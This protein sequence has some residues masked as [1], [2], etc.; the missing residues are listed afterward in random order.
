MSVYI[1]TG[2][3]GEGKGIMA[4]MQIQEALW[5]KKRVV[6]NINL[7]LENFSLKKEAKN[8]LRCSDFPPASEL[9]ALG[10]GYP[11]Y[12]EKKFGLIVLDEMGIY[13]NS[14]NFKAEG[15]ED[16]IKWLRHVRKLHW[17]LMILV[18]S[19]ES[20]DKQ[21]RN[22]LAHFQV[23]CKALDK[24]TVPFVSPISK[25]FFNRKLTLP[26]FHFGLVKRGFGPSAV[27]VD[28]WST[29]GTEFYK[30]YDTGQ[31]YDGQ[32]EGMA[33]VLDTSRVDYLK[34]PS[35]PR[36]AFYDMLYP[37]RKRFPWLDDWLPDFLKVPSIARCRYLDFMVFERDG[38]PA[39]PKKQPFSSDGFRD[40][41]TAACLTVREAS[42][43]VLIGLGA[44]NAAAHVG[45]HCEQSP[46]TVTSS[47]YEFCV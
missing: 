31:L 38:P 47:P 39:S 10:K 25:Y 29:R 26:K 44:D 30:C 4:M 6:T 41:V 24:M 33:C 16:F 3:Q 34:R 27:K 14:R 32:C 7:N 45:Q 40:W 8:V 11:T 19:A 17:D 23:K 18:Q 43:G 37:V 15:R 35:G 22:G 13:L 20:L 12:D 5:A 1:I 42:S 21:I 9:W 46:E 2:E 36:E 28:T